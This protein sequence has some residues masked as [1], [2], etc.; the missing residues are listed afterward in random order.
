MYKPKDR[1]NRRWR[2]EFNCLGY[3]VVDD[4]YHLWINA[5]MMASA[6]NELGADALIIDQWKEKAD[7]QSG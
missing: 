7:V 2:V 6:Y 4:Y 1:S 5:R 3:R